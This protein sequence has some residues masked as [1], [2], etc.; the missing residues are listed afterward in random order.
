MNCVFQAGG[1]CMDWEEHSS[2]VNSYW[3]K[4]HEPLDNHCGEELLF[5]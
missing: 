5:Q 3:F 1:G 4:G 2:V